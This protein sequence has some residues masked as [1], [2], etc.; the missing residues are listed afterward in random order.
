MKR[1][2]FITLIASVMLFWVNENVFS[3][4]KFNYTKA[5]KDVEAFVSK[6]KP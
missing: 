1:F 2:S 3:Q 4:T 6:D 5:W